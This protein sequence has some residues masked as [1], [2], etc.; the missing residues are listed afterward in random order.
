[1]PIIEY[2]QLLTLPPPLQFVSIHC[3][4][5]LFL[6]RGHNL[7]HCTLFLKR[8]HNLSSIHCYCRLLIKR[9]HPTLTI[10]E[11]YAEV[12][13]YN[14]GTRFSRSKGGKRVPANMNTKLPLYAALV[15]SQMKYFT[16]APQDPTVCTQHNDP[17]QRLIMYNVCTCHREK[18]PG[19]CWNTRNLAFHKRATLRT[20]TL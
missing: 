2:K 17:T 1:M 6:K 19:A 4:C 3:H 11:S 5:T 18:C 15:V 8:G 16:F 14:V 10:M 13:T 12:G 9:G 20:P 7:S